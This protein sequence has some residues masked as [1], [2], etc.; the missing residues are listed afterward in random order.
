M[1]NYR[2]RAI[3]LCVIASILHIFSVKAQTSPSVS[4]GGNGSGSAAPDTLYSFRQQFEM[5]S[6]RVVRNSELTKFSGVV[7]SILVA[8]SITFVDVTG[9]ASVD[10]PESLNERLARQRAE[11]MATWLKETTQVDPSILTIGWIGEDWTWFRQLVEMDAMVP[12]RQKVLEIIDS[13]TTTIPV[14]EAGLRKLEGGKTWSYLASHIFPKMRVANVSLGGYHKFMVEMM[15][16]TVVDEV[17]EIV[18][19]E[20]EAPVVEVVEVV[21]E[22]PMVRNLYVKSNAPAWLMLWMNATVEY[23]FADHWSVAVP[24][25]YSFF[26]Y[27]TSKLKF[28]TFTVVPELRWWPRNDHTGFFMNV[29]FGLNQFNYAKGGDWRYQ[30]YHGHSPALGGGIGIGFRWYF[31]RNHRWSMEAGVGAGIYHLDYSIFQNIPNGL[32][33][34]R[35]VRTFYG[36]DQASLSFAYSFGL[37]GKGVRK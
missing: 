9:I 23:D 20:E 15:P 22:E 29:H 7:D 30:T 13:K 2:K 28:R 18:I 5:D 37:K 25:Y 26:N 12:A 3:M 24:I 6:D 14:K 33:V 10:G 35:R 8:D 11:A 36:I 27:F 34:G 19:L 31:C 21:A 4:S 16:D 1:K 32:I 17:E